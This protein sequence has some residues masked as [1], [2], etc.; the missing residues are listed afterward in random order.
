MSVVSRQLYFRFIAGLT[1]TLFTGMCVA[2][3][4]AEKIDKLDGAGVIE[5]FGTIHL[6]EGNHPIIDLGDAHGLHEANEV[7]IFRAEDMH[8]RPLG[9]FR[10][11]E[12]FATHSIPEVPSGVELRD[13]DRVVYVKTLSQLGTGDGF[14]E[15][16]LR[17]QL[18]KTAERNSYSTFRQQDEADTLQRYVSRQP[19][20]VRD[21]KHFAG[22]M[23]SPS[24]SVQAAD[25]MTA[26]LSQVQLLQHYQS[27]GISID[28]N[29]GSNWLT[30]IRALRPAPEVVFGEP[31]YN[32]PKSNEETP[33]AKPVEPN[34]DPIDVVERRAERFRREANSILFTRAEEERNLAVIVL[35]ALYVEKPSNEGQWIIDQVRASQFPSLAVNEQF[36]DDLQKIL[37]RVRTSEQG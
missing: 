29:I 12:S 15:S 16:F 9:S 19:R 25:D 22:R 21:R 2:T 31:R 1:F 5:F 33:A 23:R 27:L 28:R 8:F 13:G 4:V 3:A 14:R 11:E 7:A 6:Q 32:K 17:Q 18:I 35:A 10:I 20:W 24:V 37:K 36:I 34:Q 26:V 30:V